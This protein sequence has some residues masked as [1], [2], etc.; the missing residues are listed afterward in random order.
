M[1]R[2]NL[3]NYLRNY[4]GLEDNSIFFDS[5]TQEDLM[6]LFSYVDDDTKKKFAAYFLM[7]DLENLSMEELSLLKE[8]V[9]KKSFKQKR[10]IL[11]GKDEL[12]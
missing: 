2:I 6:E 12:K 8:M 10:K 5:L 3:I 4:Y 11:K 7:E 9:G 1:P